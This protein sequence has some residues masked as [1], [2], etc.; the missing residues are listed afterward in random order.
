MENQ[1][2]VFSNNHSCED[3]RMQY[4]LTK[5]PIVKNIEIGIFSFWVNQSIYQY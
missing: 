2:K 5:L 3:I 1:E 4:K